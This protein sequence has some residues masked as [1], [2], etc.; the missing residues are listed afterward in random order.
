M[1]I[2][3][4]FEE[5]SEE[6]LRLLAVDADD[7]AVISS[8]V[9][10]A[11]LPATEM[12]WLPSKNRFAMLLNRFRWEDRDRASAQHREFE[13]VQTML[14]ADTVTKAAFSGIHPRD[15]DEVLSLLSV[16]FAETDAPSGVLTL[17]FAGDGAIALTIECLEVTLK[18]VS[19]PYIAPSGAAP[20]H[21][22]E[23]E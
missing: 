20:H 11:V 8:L 22:V 9:Q 13:R 15:E 14:V 21:S 7:L 10:D 2:D 4:T 17:N 5:G 12:S 1:A 6:P 19:R 3:A 23:D 18:D 16:E